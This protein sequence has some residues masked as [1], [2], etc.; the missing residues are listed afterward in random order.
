[1]KLPSPLVLIT[2]LIIAALAL[3]ESFLIKF[4]LY[5]ALVIIGCIVI[6]KMSAHLVRVY[7]GGILDTTR[8]RA[9]NGLLIGVLAIVALGAMVSARPQLLTTYQPEKFARSADIVQQRGFYP[10]ESDPAQNR[11]VWTQDRATLVF[12]FLV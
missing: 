2:I 9:V 8:I 12:D 10:T 6:R 5:G 7:G 1:M 11:F 3:I 4:F